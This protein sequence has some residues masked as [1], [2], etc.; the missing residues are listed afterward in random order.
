M[1]PLSKHL[2]F[3]TPPPKK[4]LSVSSPS[5][6]HTV[7]LLPAAEI[8][9]NLQGFSLTVSG[10]SFPCVCIHPFFTVARRCLVS[11]YASVMPSCADVS[12]TF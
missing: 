10:C 6:L 7:C 9:A 2:H 4:L 5:C 12:I 1:M 8:L 11:L 3:L